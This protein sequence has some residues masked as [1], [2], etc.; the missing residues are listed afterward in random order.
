MKVLV[1]GADGFIGRHI[2][3]YLRD[4]GCAVIAHARNPS[5]LAAMGFDTLAADLTDPACHDTAFWA[6]RLPDK[7]HI[8][9]AAGLLTASPSA[10]QAVHVLAPAAAYAAVPRGQVLLL[11]AVGIE[12]ETAFAHWRRAGEAV[13]REAGATVLRA[14]LVLANGSYGG[15]SLIRALAAL[16][17][18]TPLVGRGD[19]PFNP[20]HAQDLAAVIHACLLTPPGAGVW[21]I[22]GPETITQQRMVTAVQSW[23]GLPARAIWN[24]PLGLAKALGHMGDALRLG[25][26]SASAVAQL[27]AGVLA[28]PE[29]LLQKIDARPRGFSQF[30]T[31]H[32]AGSQDLWQAR[33]YLIKPLIRLTL[34]VLWLASAAIGL[35]LPAE[36]FLP[37]VSALPAP[38]AIFLARGGGLADAALG[39]ALLRNWRPKATALAQLGLVAGYSIGLTLIAPGLWLD[40]FGGLLKNLPV[41]ALILVHLALVEER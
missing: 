4:Q 2:A 26:I 18:V 11:S 23:L 19:Q 30:L 32:P 7:A 39:L 33:L 22:G 20:I 6:A 10:F 31:A 1:L 5:R 9:N 25:P 16:P 38:L 28:E 13:A 17:L 41:L 37:M 27:Q 24:L 8:V 29:A 21:Q 36:Q 12:A 14:G 35:L 34:A 3:F 40:P 15:S